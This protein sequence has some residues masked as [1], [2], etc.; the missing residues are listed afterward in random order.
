MSHLYQL[1]STLDQFFSNPKQPILDYQ[2]CSMDMGQPFMVG[3][4]PLLAYGEQVVEEQEYP[5]P[6]V[7]GQIKDGLDAD[8]SPFMALQEPLMASEESLAASEPSMLVGQ[9]LLSYLAPVQS[10]ERYQQSLHK[11]LWNLGGNE[12]DYE[13]IGVKL[14]LENATGQCL[15]PIEPKLKWENIDDL[16]EYGG[17]ITTLDTCLEGNGEHQEVPEVK[18]ELEIENITEGNE[19]VSLGLHNVNEAINIINPEYSK[20]LMCTKWFCEAEL[21]K[22]LAICQAKRP[23][24]DRIR[25]S[26]IKI[27]RTEES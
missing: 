13:T 5:E 25:L 8:E 2:Q 17:S 26:D 14:E 11:E 3:V 16:K 4:K 23:C 24:L 21:K 27:K 6:K 19:G 20:C 10:A 9:Q 12:E 22:H 1:M 15:G 18:L 7:E